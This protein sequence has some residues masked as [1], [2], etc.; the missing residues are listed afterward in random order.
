MS[1]KVYSPNWKKIIH[2]LTTYEDGSEVPLDKALDLL[3]P[4]FKEKI[5]QILGELCFEEKPIKKPANNQT[6]PPMQKINTEKPNVKVEGIIKAET[7]KAICI[8]FPNKEKDTWIP[9]STIR[10]EYDIKN[11]DDKQLFCIDQWV[12]KKNS[13]VA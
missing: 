3:Y 1:E 13:V 9:K 11:K 4:I 2:D 12:L 10:S 8:D 7:P 6:K 5:G